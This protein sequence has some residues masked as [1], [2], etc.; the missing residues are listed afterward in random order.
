MSNKN[1]LVEWN[2]SYIR[3][4]ATDPRINYEIAGFFKKNNNQRLRFYKTG[5]S[6]IDPVSQ[7]KYVLFPTNKGEMLW[8]THPPMDGFWPSMEDLRFGGMIQGQTRRRMNVLFGKYGTWIY[9][10][11][12]DT[13]DN[14]LV[15]T[16]QNK[17]LAF[18]KKMEQLTQVKPSWSVDDVMN[19]IVDFTRFANT[20]L[21]YHIEF[22]PNFRNEN[23]DSYSQTV[24]NKLSKIV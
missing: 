6:K 13:P 14:R 18:H 5:V 10:G 15:I 11:F 24:Y 3:T 17:W 2:L 20:M 16:L 8:H 22:I 21:G 9:K 1:N 12:V 19:C 4:H 23:I 7:R